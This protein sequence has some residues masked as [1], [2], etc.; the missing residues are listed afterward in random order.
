MYIFVCQSIFFWFISTFFSSVF[1]L[2][3]KDY[4]GSSW[5]PLKL[6]HLATTVVGHGETLM[7]GTI[8]IAVSK[9]QHF[10]ITCGGHTT[11]C[12][13]K[14]RNKLWYYLL[15]Y[16]TTISLS[17][18]MEGLLIVITKIITVSLPVTLLNLHPFSFIT[19]TFL[20]SSNYF[21]I[22]FPLTLTIIFLINF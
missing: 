6:H 7:V 9:I 5:R 17:T 22:P 20:F 8:Y 2:R 10:I 14:L 13:S 1:Y 4:M 16:V 15:N 12:K 19:A 3:W 11:I 21:G 18:I